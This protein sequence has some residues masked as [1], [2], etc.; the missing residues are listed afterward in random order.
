MCEAPRPK[1]ASRNVLKILSAGNT[2]SSMAVEKVGK[3]IIVSRP[4]ES[5]SFW[6]PY[7]AVVWFEKDRA[8]H[9][10]F[11]GIGLKAFR[12]E[13][14]ALDFGFAIARAWLDRRF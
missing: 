10:E 1:W 5:G 11:N 14:A 7:A 12:S 6:R 3:Y 9:H 13:K 4:T 8:H 2:F